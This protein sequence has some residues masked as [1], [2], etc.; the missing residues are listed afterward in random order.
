[1]AWANEQWESIEVPLVLVP[2]RGAMWLARMSHNSADVWRAVGV[3]A[4]CSELLHMS[5]VCVE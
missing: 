5:S 1:V 3:L 2:Y 4:D